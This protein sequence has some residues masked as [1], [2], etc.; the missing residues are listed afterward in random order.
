LWNY[1]SDVYQVFFFLENEEFKLT[2]DASGV[3]VGEEFKLTVDASGVGVGEE[4]KLTVD[5]S[6]VGVG[7]SNNHIQL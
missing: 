7:Q 4:F 3:G 6:G 2:V 1:F 5:A